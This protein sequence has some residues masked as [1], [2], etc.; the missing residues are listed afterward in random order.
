MIKS[1]G[2][3]WNE[4]TE[5]KDPMT[6]RLVRRLTN[7][8][9]W[10][11]KPTY[12]TNTT[13]TADGEWMIFARADQGKTAFFKAHV[14]SGDLTQLTDPVHGMGGPWLLHKGTREPS[15]VYDGKGMSGITACI[16]PRSRVAMYMVGRSVRSVHLDTLEERVLWDNFGEDWVDASMSVNPAETHVLIPLMPA[17]P[18]IKLGK[19]A[20]RGYRDWLAEGG[21]RTRYVEVT[22]LDGA[23]KIVFEDEGMGCGHCPHCPTDDDLILIDRDRAPEFWCGGDHRASSRCWTY[24]LSTGELTPLTP[25]SAWKFQTHSAWTWDGKCIVYHGRMSNNGF[26]LGVMDRD[27]QNVRE[28]EFPDA[29]FY[30]HVSAAPDRPAIVI[31]GNVSPDQLFWLYYDEAEPRFERIAVH[32]SDWASLPG[33]LTHPHPQTDPQ[34]RWIVYHVAQAGRSDIHAVI[35]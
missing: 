31:D 25:N 29:T 21:M 34:G 5:F 3:S 14:Q 22:L 13:F 30:G 20:T 28:F 11:E 24:R 4:S 10:N 19:P 35:L 32:G 2:D 23:R 9:I 6:G 17:H 12:H 16:A 15:P 27:G 8:G 7:S 33:Q 1:K 26:Y 18:E